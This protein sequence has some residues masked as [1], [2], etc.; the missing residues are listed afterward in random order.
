M[1]ANVNFVTTLQCTLCGKEAAADR[2]QTVCPACQGSLFVRYD[3]KAAAKAVNPKVLSARTQADRSMWKYREV[4]PAET[5]VTLGEGQ[6]PLLPARR[7]GAAMGAEKLYVK[8][9]GLNPTGSFKA[10]G[11]GCAVTMLKQFG[12]KKVAIPTAGNAGSALAAYA[13]EAGIEAHI[14]APADVPKGNLAEYNFYGAKVTL[15]DGLISDCAKLVQQGREREGWYDV[16]TMKEPYRVEGKKTMGYEVVEQLGWK[17]PDVIFYPT[18][19]GV[20]L[21]GMWKAFDEMQ[22]M[23]WI[24][25]ERPRM[26]AV[27]AAGCPPVVEAF[28]A[29]AERMVACTNATTM[30]AGLRV[31]KPYADKIILD[32]LRSS[33][34]T[35]LA[36]SDAAIKAAVREL[37]SSEGIFAAPEGAATVVAARQ[38]YQSGWMRPDETVVLYNTGGGLKYLDVLQ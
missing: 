11:L 8:D 3:L 24:S 1:L 2:L 37:A 32:I 36:V 23:G 29:H 35:A 20:G 19:G 22:E 14:F 10:R 13:A 30:A 31:P 15:V 25:A 5:P 28:N 4:M 33:R 27:Q 6:T 17:V 26:V 9:E 34:G 21:I 16:S 18:G 12:V 38:L 7:L